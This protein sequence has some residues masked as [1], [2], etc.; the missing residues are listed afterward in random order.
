[1]SNLIESSEFGDWLIGEIARAGPQSK[2]THSEQS[3][4]SGLRLESLKVA[5]K[6]LLEFLNLQQTM[7]SAASA[8][9]R[10]N[11]PT[12]PR[13]RQA[14]YRTRTFMREKKT[15]SRNPGQDGAHMR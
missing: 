12:E 9:R 4:A 2:S 5:K 3:L 6:L 8:A 15:A 14:A 13:V 11:P 10:R 7:L 1:M